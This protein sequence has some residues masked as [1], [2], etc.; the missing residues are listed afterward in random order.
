MNRKIFSVL[1]VMPEPGGY[2]AAKFSRTPT[3]KSYQDWV[4]ELTQEGAEKFYNS[5]YFEYGHSS[6]ADLAHLMVIFENISM[7]AR[8]I[9]L[10]DQ[11]IDA[12]SRSTRYV[13]Y[14]Q[15]VFI[16]PP[17]IKDDEKTLELFNQT[18]KE[19]VGLYS[20]LIEKVS[21][22][23]SKKYSKER[24]EDMDDDRYS[25]TMKARA[26]DVARYLL[27]CAGPKSMGVIAS[28]R[29]W[30]R[31]I[32]KF[33]SSSLLECQEIGKELQEAICKNEAFNASVIK[34]NGLNWLSEEQKSEIKKLIAGNNIA[35]PTL[36]KY[37]AKKEYPGNVYQ[38]L[39]K[40]RYLKNLGEPNG[41]RGVTMFEGITPEIDFVTT[42]LYKSTPYSYGQLL[43][44][45]KKADKG[46]ISK[47][48]DLAFSLRGDHDQLMKEASTQTLTFDICMDVGGFR[49]LHRHRNCIQILKPVTGDYGYD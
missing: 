12:Q 6:I 36:V 20:K 5:M 42:L 14:S 41:K 49:D 15:A 4:L 46:L 10:D 31:I 19:M 40:M 34:I 29:T 22:L 44:V 3:Y 9:L 35:L 28:G 37:A 24:P 27:P 38:E 47:I 16:I 43:K 13:D 23:Y 18:I 21:A 2:A 25:R 33:L 48:I 7:P 26:I 45:V 17:E 39:G 32:T 30:E 8:H 11:L 1:G